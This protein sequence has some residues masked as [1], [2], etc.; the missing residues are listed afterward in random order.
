MAAQN[1]CRY[2]NFGYCKYGE[3]CRK[4]HV[5]EL[6]DD[7]SCDPFM[8]IKRHPKECKYYRNYNRCKFNPCKFAHVAKRNSDDKYE[9]L[10]E[11]VDMIEEILKNKVD[12]E[13]KIEE[14]DE[15]IVVQEEI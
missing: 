12:L 6:C 8:C 9:E 14:V 15:K 2:N 13:T 10:V 3:V 4:C 1:I 5:D 7:L 11:K